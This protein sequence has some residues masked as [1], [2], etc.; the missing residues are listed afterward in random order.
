MLKLNTFSITARCPRTGQ[1]GVAVSTAVPCVGSLVPHVRSGVGAVA[2]QSFVNV[3]LGIWGIEYL[4]QGLSADETL[5]RL[6]ERDSDPA[7]RQFAVVDRHGRSAAYTGAEC[8]GWCGHLIAE[9]VAIAGNMLV[10]EATLTAMR[11]AFQ[12]SA[13]EPLADRLLRSLE[14]GQAAGGDKRGKQSAAIYVVDTEDYAMV[15]IR[16]DEHTDPV[17]ELRRIYTVAQQ[18]L[19]PLTRMM[20]T[21]ANPRGNYDIEEARRTGILQD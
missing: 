6:A 21:K 18:K 15:D 5:R 17:A 16:V 12:S 13:G 10:G 3:Y 7:K 14:A 20:P 11:D 9:N 2:T 8:D 1:F 19:F 4:A